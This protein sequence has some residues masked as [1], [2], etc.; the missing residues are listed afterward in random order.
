MTIKCETAQDSL[1]KK[2]KDVIEEHESLKSVIKEQDGNINNFKNM[3]EM[4]NSKLMEL[5]DEM[6]AEIHNLKEENHSIK[7]NH[8]NISNFKKYIA[9]IDS[10]ISSL[11]TET[12]NNSTKI[13]STCEIIQ[14]LQINV[15]SNESRTKRIEDVKFNGVDALRSNLENVKRDIANVNSDVEEIKLS[16]K[17]NKESIGD[18]IRDFRK[19][20]INSSNRSYS[21]EKL[22]HPSEIENLISFESPKQKSEESHSPPTPSRNNNISDIMKYPEDIHARD[23]GRKNIPC[24]STDKVDNK[25]SSSSI[26]VVISSDQN[27]ASLNRFRCIHEKRAEQLYVGG[28][29][30]DCTE[31][32]M[33]NFL[34]ELNVEF[35]RIRFFT[36]GQYSN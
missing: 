35:T 26:E 2:L 24:E 36:K 14:K 4:S 33:R 19:E 23:L 11:A 28:I 12:E 8:A 15:K 29:M 1:D 20:L 27:K 34:A 22:G 30:K 21:P 7:Q 10:A 17:L 31:N 32:D 13:D 5:M 6:K 3:I 16:I 9:E 25:L 18:L